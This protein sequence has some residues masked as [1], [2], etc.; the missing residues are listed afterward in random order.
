MSESDLQKTCVQ[1]FRLQYP[2]YDKLLFAVPNGGYRNG[3]EA[4]NLKKQ[5]VVS[6]V[7][8]LIL[9]VGAKGYNSLCI[10]LKAGKNGLT[11]NQKQWIGAAEKQGNKCLVIRS[12]ESFIEAVNEYL[13]NNNNNNLK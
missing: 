7:A 11:D 9:L 10:E 2:Q 3:R 13:N 1:Y 5:G 8:D 4:A 12:I 6:G